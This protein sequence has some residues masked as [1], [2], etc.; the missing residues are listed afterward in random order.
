M[1]KGSGRRPAAIPLSQVHANW[2]RIFARP[3]PCSHENF[4]AEG[5][6][7]VCECGL[8]LVELWKVERENEARDRELAKLAH[9]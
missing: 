7:L 1:S 2:D 9:D 3:A 8:D 4:H 6:K 5:G